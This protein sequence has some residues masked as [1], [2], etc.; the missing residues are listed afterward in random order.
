[1]TDVRISGQTAV[2]TVD[3]ADEYPLGRS[4]AGKKITAANLV[5]AFLAAYPEL[6]AIEA[7][8]SAADKTPY[9]TGAG[10]ASLA[11]IT[12]AARALLDDAN[13]AAMLTTLGLSSLMQSLIDDADAATARATLGIPKELDYVERTTQMD[14]TATTFATAQT[15]ITSNS[16][17][18]DGSTKIAIEG[19]MP[20]VLP[21]T[22]K[23]IYATLW[24]D[25]SDLGIVASG[26]RQTGDQY[27]QYYFY[28]V[29]TPAAGSHTYY[30]KGL[31]DSGTG[32]LGAGA[33]GSGTYAPAYLRLSRIT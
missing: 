3:S 27:A 23:T 6:G 18:V 32:H 19:H 26:K 9:F 1:M 25:S 10:T 20:Y 30:I 12:S 5:A 17:T 15:F 21:A 13:A 33:G 31:T 22:D 24:E 14:V 8:T 29:R 28:R 11:T 16:I 2:T 7:L 4:S